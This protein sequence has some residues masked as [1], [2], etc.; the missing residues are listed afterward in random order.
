LPSPDWV[1][2][3]AAPAGRVA[4]VIP[5]RNQATLLRACL[6]AVCAEAEAAG[7]EVVVVDDASSDEVAA[8]VPASGVRLIRLEEAGGPYHARNVGWRATDAEIL[9]FADA[10]TRPRPGWLR[11]LVVAVEDPTVGVAG[12]DSLVSAATNRVE[13]FFAWWQP[14]S[15]ESSISNEFLPFVSGGNLAARRDVLE[16]LGGFWEV[17]SGGDADICWRAQLAL[18][19][20]VVRVPDAVV[21]LVPR[22][23]L[24]HAFPQ[25]HRYGYYGRRLEHRFAIR[26]GSGRTPRSDR[27]LPARLMHLR[28]RAGQ[29]GFA[30]IV[31][32]IA[33]RL[34]LFSFLLGRRGGERSLSKDLPERFEWTA[35]Q[36]LAAQTLRGQ[37]VAPGD[38][39]PAEAELVPEDSLDDPA[40][41]QRHL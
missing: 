4:V 1:R 29:V 24:R 40:A 37:R 34:L 15:A 35:E 32:R 33:G 7:A 28:R 11:A 14:M 19:L 5:V 21:D 26:H 10:R 38:G 31:A 12:G 22:S 41:K 6:E 23:A 20:R 2:R 17:L 30:G 8:A 9:V 16:R 3:G 18:G 25:Y 36:L 13:R 39:L 27:S